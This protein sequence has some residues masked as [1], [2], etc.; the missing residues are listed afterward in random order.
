MG[1]YDKSQRAT[2]P[3][4]DVANKNRSNLSKKT[5]DVPVSLQGALFPLPY[6]LERHAFLLH[7]L[8]CPHPPDHVVVRRGYIHAGLGSFVGGVVVV[9]AVAGGGGVV[10]RHEALVLHTEQCLSTVMVR[11]K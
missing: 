7:S 4:M 8:Q 6:F 5:L 9:V 10:S 11:C 3:G 2:L 1:E